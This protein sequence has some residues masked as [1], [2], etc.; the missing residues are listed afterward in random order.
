MSD[1]PIHTEL[2]LVAFAS[3]QDLRAS[4]PSTPA[5]VASITA[6]AIVSYARRTTVTADL[7]IERAL[8]LNPGARRLYGHA[9]G[10]I[11]RASSL[12]VAA[13]ADRVTARMLGAWRLEIVS[14]T[15][16]F[17]WLVIHAP[18]GAPPITMIELRRP[19]GF[20]RRVELGQPIDMVFQLP[21]D[22][23]FEELAGLVDW[24]EDPSTE[25]HLL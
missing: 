2:H 12:S 4:S 25:I 21:L 20:G 16:S 1:A 18:H 9:L 14:E 22:P 7:A 6:S 15:A 8:R 10:Q 5:T 23:G 19:D 3:L 11:A 13:A 24:F 17:P